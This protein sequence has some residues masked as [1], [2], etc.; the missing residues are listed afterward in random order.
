MNISRNNL[1]K[2][3][4]SFLLE[5]NS[6]PKKYTINFS[7][8]VVLVKKHSNDKI[9]IIQ[10][11]QNYKGKPISE[12][13]PMP[14]EE[15]KGKKFGAINAYE[16]I[17]QEI[18]INDQ[19]DSGNFKNKFKADP[20]AGYPVILCNV[21]SKPISEMF[22]NMIPEDYKDE[23]DSL[24]PEG[25][26]FLL[27]INPRTRRVQR[28]DFGV[29]SPEEGGSPNCARDDGSKIQGLLGF[30]AVGTFILKDSGI[31]ADLVKK[32]N[33]YVLTDASL[34]AII[35]K[36]KSLTQGSP[37]IDYVVIDGC[38][39]VNKAI[40]TAKSNDCADYNVIPAGFTASL[41]ST[42][43]SM[44][45]FITGEHSTST[46]PSTS[47]DNCASMA[48]KLVYLAK[49]G[50]FPASLNTTILQYPPS[51]VEYARKNLV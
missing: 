33:N 37:A 15:I 8:S 9:E 35:S 30:S 34:D 6:K 47:G 40:A 2:L 26:V 25:H 3:I 20:D 29:F 49:N 51:T 10:W 12:S 46:V 18:D 22:I 38:K 17:M 43:E 23:L 27:F 39:H 36:T 32:E 7:K 13:N 1:K 21:M 48:Y 4:E 11:P 45:D 31:E 16:T 28:F 44:Y 24:I 50:K 19:K 41:M 14:L 5:E 42:F